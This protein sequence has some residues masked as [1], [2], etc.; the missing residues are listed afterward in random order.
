MR[1]VSIRRA[2]VTFAAM[3]AAVAGLIYLLN[4]GAA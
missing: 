2:A 3:V 4:F 1:D